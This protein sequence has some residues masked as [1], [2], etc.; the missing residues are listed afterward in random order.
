[1]E[2]YSPFFSLPYLAM[3]AAATRNAA[4]L[5][6]GVRSAGARA[7]WRAASAGLALAAMVLNAEAM[8]DITVVLDR[9][10]RA[11]GEVPRACEV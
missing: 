6:R 11:C 2:G 9:G 8:T 5:R 7:N 1:M 4:G 10:R 3:A